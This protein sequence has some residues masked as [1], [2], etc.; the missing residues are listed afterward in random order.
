MRNPLPAVAAALSVGLLTLT[1]TT[2]NADTAPTFTPTADS[3][4]NAAT[5]T[6]NIGGVLSRLDAPPATERQTY[7][8]FT[9]TGIPAGD[10]V[11]SATLRLV[12]TD[13]STG[14]VTVSTTPTTWAE[15]TITWNTKPT[16]GAQ[17]TSGTLAAGSGVATT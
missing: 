9:V 3:V 13:T 6:T 11:E 14:A 17:V 1:P 12:N 7:I 8:K 16:P 5:P 10:T 4:V 15:N 2:A